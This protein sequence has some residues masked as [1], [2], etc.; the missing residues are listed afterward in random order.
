MMEIGLNSLPVDRTCFDFVT[1]KPHMSM[2]EI[3]IGIWPFWLATVMSFLLLMLFAQF[4]TIP[5]QILVG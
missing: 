3:I 1:N 2:R 4:A 5:P